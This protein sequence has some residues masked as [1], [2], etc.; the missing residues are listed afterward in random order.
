MH[1]VTC[2]MQ[3]AMKETLLIKV[4]QETL[5]DVQ[6]EDPWT[7]LQSLMVWC[8]IMEPLNGLGQS[9]SAMM[10]IIWWKEM[11]PQGFA[12]VMEIGMEAYPSVFQV[13]K[14]LQ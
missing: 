1:F 12:R 9:T 6:I 3:G 10:V 5:Q 11:R 8:A 13:H 7:V 2:G 4:G 14:V